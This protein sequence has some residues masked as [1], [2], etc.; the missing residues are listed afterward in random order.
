M[1]IDRFED[2][3]IWKDARDLCKFVFELTSKEIFNKDFRFRDQIRASAGSVMDNIAEGFE[4]GGNKEFGQFLYYSKGSCGETRSQGYRALD[5]K[6]ISEAEFNKL[7][8]SALRISTKIAHLIKY[9]KDSEMKGA[10]YH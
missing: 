1:K 2:M 8:E 7:N 10:K 4:R 9:L 5:F 6:Y 3:E